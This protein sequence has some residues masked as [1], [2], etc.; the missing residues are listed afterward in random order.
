MKRLILLTVLVATPAVAAPDAVTMATLLDQMHDLDG[1]T[2]FPDPAYK[3]VQFS[4]YDRRSNLPGG[5]DWFANS[6]GF[7]SEPIPA[8]ESVQR[9][10]D[11]KGIGE[12]VIC[13]VKQPG[14]IVRTWTA[15]IEGRI[16]MFLD[17]D[18]APTFDGTATDF[19]MHR[20][21]TLAKSAGLTVDAKDNAFEQRF[22]D[23]FPIPF[24]KRCRLVW[25]GNIKRVHFYHVEVRHYPPGTTVRTFRG[26]ELKTSAEAITRASNDLRG[27]PAS[28]ATQPA[29]VEQTIAAGE[30]REVLRLDGP[31]AISELQ[32]SLRAD[33]VRAALRATVLR[34]HFDGF[35]APQV[36][37]PLGDF[38][39][40]APGIVPFRTFPMSV[41]P[42]GL[43]TCRFAMPFARSAAIVIDNRG[44][45]PVTIRL[46]ARRT[47][48][49]WD[50]RSLHFH[51]RWRVQHD[52]LARSGNDATDLPFLLARGQGLYVGTAVYLMNPCPVPTAGG[53]WW[54]EGDEKIFVD[55]DRGP[56][57]FGTGSEDYF[58]YAWSQSDIFAYPYFAQPICSGPDTRGYITNS[59]WHVLDA[60]PFER[61]LAF[62]MELYSHAPTARMSYARLSYYYARPGVID[63]SVN[64]QDADLR[65][66]P[67]P[68]WRVQAG[69]AATGA[70]FFEAEDMV[71]SGD[72]AEI[73]ADAQ[74]SGGKLARLKPGTGASNGLLLR[75]EKP[76]K[77]NVVL[78]CLSG[79]K[80]VHFV[81]TIDGSILKHDQDQERVDLHTPHLERLVNLWFDPIE[82]APGEHRL[83]IDRADG[84]VDVDFAWIRPGK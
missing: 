29:F 20:F 45:Q 71:A 58:N 73:V 13:D 17:D 28:P 22:A 56:S 64:L 24:A 2:R 50:D 43:M 57:F 6:D 74:C 10:P 1:L 83:G 48:R 4:S 18:P 63:D 55:D 49:A 34:I 82:L 12:Y 37:S 78:T 7:G 51:A 76:G 41:L 19:L 35:P 42:D 69:G 77:Y 21:A 25:T 52:L 84:P 8:F 30:S 39:G 15:T 23:Y 14:A 66:V 36:R 47:E 16:Q 67:L 61:F 5:P 44:T 60:I 62:Y 54:G 32:A 79:P 65:V 31:A 80:H 81:A 26:E 40:A 53:N 3:L 27:N 75:V 70:T 38:F 33:D 72:A 59:R 46:A 68:A 11:D 9:E